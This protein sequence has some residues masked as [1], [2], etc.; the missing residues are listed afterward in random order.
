MSGKTTHGVEGALDQGSLRSLVQVIL[1]ESRS[2]IW[3]VNFEHSMAVQVLCES[4]WPDIASH[5]SLQ[6]LQK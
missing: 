4:C 5:D 1:K 6:E 2:H 3:D